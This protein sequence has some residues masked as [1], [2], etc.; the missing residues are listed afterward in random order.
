MAMSDKR[1]YTLD[2]LAEATGLEPRTIRSYIERG[3]LPNADARGRAA[4]YGEDHL[5]RLRVIQM[6]RR[7]DPSL[8]LAQVRVRLQQLNDGDI[9]SLAQGVLSARILKGPED[10]D[11]AVDADEIDD[12]AEA[13]A[14][15]QALIGMSADR[16]SHD[17]AGAERLVVALRKLTGAT[18]RPTA[19]RFERWVR[20]AVTEDIE[21]SVRAD[22][23]EIQVGAFREFADLL[24]DLLTR[25]DAISD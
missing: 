3:L 9:A 19:S 21:L 1:T 17:L 22:F 13:D 25:S 16:P 5:H 6:I 24:R 2:A 15:S 11:V 14:A 10:E 18:T 23:S 20:I 8:S 4:G 7:A 12:E